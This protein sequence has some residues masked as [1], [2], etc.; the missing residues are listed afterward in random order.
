MPSSFDG[1]GDP[2]RGSSYRG[3]IMV[4]IVCLVV[5]ALLWLAYGEALDMVPPGVPTGEDAPPN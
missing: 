4:A 2:Y 1:A 5:I 3:W